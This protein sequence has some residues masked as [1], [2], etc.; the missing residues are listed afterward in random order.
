M[1]RFKLLLIIA[2]LVGFAALAY[3]G[4]DKGKARFLHQYL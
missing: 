3:A 1:K 2:L 4:F